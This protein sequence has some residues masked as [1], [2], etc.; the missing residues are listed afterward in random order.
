VEYGLNN[1]KST[2][3]SAVLTETWPK[4]WNVV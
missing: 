1:N 4:Q 3:L 2:Q